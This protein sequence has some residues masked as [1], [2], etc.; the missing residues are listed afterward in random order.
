MEVGLEKI[1]K[2]EVVDYLKI[3]PRNVT[4]KRLAFLSHIRKF[5]CSNLGL[6]TGYP[7]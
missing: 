4:I 6:K 3:S 2:E 1:T 7:D 5:P